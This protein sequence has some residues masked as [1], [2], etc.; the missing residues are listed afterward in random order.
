MAAADEV[1]R[2][3]RSNKKLP[4]KY[5]DSVK[6]SVISV[7]GQSIK[8]KNE[9]ILVELTRAS[10]ELHRTELATGNPLRRQIPT[11]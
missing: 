10:L 4:E 8:I 7:E 1:Q 11:T 6:K 3:M 5:G 2:S 9:A